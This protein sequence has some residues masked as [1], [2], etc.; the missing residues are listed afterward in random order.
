MRS[1]LFAASCVVTACYTVTV[2]SAPADPVISYL[3]GNTEWPQSFNPS[4]VQPGGPNNVASGL[5]VR[6]QNC[7]KWAPG[8]CVGCNVGPNWPIS[9][10]FPGSVVTFAKEK[11]DGTFEDPYLV[12]APVPND[13]TLSDYGTEDPRLQY[14]ATTGLYHLFYTC[15]GHDCPRLCHAVTPDPTVPW[16]YGNWT[17]LGAVFGNDKNSCN[18]KSGALLLRD[19]LPHY[20]I[21]GAGQ[22]GLATTSDLLNFTTI[23]PAFVTKREQGFDS[24][25]VEAGPPPM[26]MFDGNYFFFYNS[27]NN[28]ASGSDFG[29]YNP[30]WLVLDGDDPSNILQR[31][32]VPLLSP[33]HGWE[34]GVAPYECNVHNVTFL[35]AARHVSSSSSGDIFDVWFGG[36]DAVIGTARVLVTNP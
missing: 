8:Q 29:S 31:S 33:V 15:Y 5:L 30:G 12:F 22:I 3:D 26:R 10:Y 16:P 35:E 24:N 28:S 14:D 13:P 25:L 20:L 23:N 9:P 34:Q 32:D 27:A 6:A 21:W 36:A 18:S 2:I 7:S 17:R 11:A 4:Y 1:F 19:T